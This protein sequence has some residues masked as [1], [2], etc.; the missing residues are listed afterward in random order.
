MRTS[1][2]TWTEAISSRMSFVATMGA[3]GTYK[4]DTSRPT[5]KTFHQL[6]PSRGYGAIWSNTTVPLCSTDILRDVPKLRFELNVRLHLVGC[7]KNSAMESRKAC[8]RRIRCTYTEA[9]ASLE[10]KLTRW[11]TSA[12]PD[13]ITNRDIYVI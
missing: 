4:T 1:F 7:H 8:T 9:R 13:P 12:K 11:G 2:V 6:R 5:T 3:L 10:I